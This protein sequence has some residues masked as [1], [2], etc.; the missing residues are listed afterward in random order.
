MQT[1]NKSVAFLAPWV[2]SARAELNKQETNKKK[3]KKK[4]RGEKKEI[5]YIISFLLETTWI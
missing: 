3:R 4:G 1:N 5:L 2:V